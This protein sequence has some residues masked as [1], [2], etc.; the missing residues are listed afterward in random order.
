MRNKKVKKIRKLFE[1]LK[2]SRA[3][4][5]GP[6]KEVMGWRRFKKLM[7]GQRPYNM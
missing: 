4:P 6:F 3:L 2:V 7:T 5:L 1:Q